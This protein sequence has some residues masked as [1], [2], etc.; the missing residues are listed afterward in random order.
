MI[1]D[2]QAA[3]LRNLLAGRL[4]SHGLRGRSARGGIVWTMV[5]LKKRGLTHGNPDEITQAGVDALV[6]Y[7]KRHGG[8]P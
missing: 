8:G 6:A 5:A 4:A 3:V 7:T 2:A 1:T